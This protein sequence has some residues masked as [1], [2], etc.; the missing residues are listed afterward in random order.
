MLRAS[1]C[2]GIGL[3]LGAAEIDSILVLDTQKAVDAFQKSQASNSS[4]H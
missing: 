1:F 3:T 4:Q 2:T